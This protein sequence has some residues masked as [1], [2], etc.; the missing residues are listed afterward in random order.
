[1][2]PA[3]APKPVRVLDALATALAVPDGGSNYY[4]DVSFAGYG[5]DIAAPALVQYPAVFIGD[6]SDIG[7]HTETTRDNRVLWHRRCR[8]D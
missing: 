6:T 8:S 7:K 2:P 1:M 4:H 3:T 5:R